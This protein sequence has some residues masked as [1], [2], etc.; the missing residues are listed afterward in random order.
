MNRLRLTVLIATV[1]GCCSTALW[2]TSPEGLEI[3]ERI[4]LPNGEELQ[5]IVIPGSLPP[6]VKVACVSLPSPNPGGGV[7][8]LTGVPAFDWSYGCS[9]TSAAMIAGYYD[10][11]GYPDM[12]TGPAN[13]GHCPLDNSV[14]GYG[15]CPLSASEQD[16]DGRPT[17]GHV[18][19]YYDSYNHPGPDPFDVG[20]WPEHSPPDCAGDFMKTNQAAFGNADG[21]TSLYYYPSGSKYSG[22]DSA[23]GGF[24][25]ELFFES[26][27][28]VVLDRFTQAT[29]S[30]GG[31]SFSDYQQ[32]IDEGRPVLIHLSGHTVVGI[33]YNTTG[34]IVY[35]HDTWDHCDHSMTW[36]GLY[37][38]RSIWAVTVVEL[39]D[40]SSVFSDGFESNDTSGWSATTP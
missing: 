32:E 5:R 10:R 18:D 31:F 24:G 38:G 25:V 22:T 7:N 11:S 17:K 34:S 21:A 8:V 6:A 16:V 14:W 9:A 40:N 28:Y 30:P 3:T 33:G 29:V 20:G 4:L 35:L 12:Y 36:T 23:D 13:G 26:R 19:D 15:K 1:V 2:A 37:D 39:A 27:G